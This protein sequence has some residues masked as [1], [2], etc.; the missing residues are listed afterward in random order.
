MNWKNHKFDFEVLYE[1]V[2]LTVKHISFSLCKKKI[3]S[4]QV[5]EWAKKQSLY[6]EVL[7]MYQIPE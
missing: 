2:V 4:G 5:G 3:Q 6:A 1:P 7:A